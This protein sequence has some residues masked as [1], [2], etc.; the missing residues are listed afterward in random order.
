MVSNAVTESITSKFDI[1]KKKKK[2]KLNPYSAVPARYH[3][4]IPDVSVTME[5]LIHYQTQ[6]SDPISC[7]GNSMER[8]NQIAY[9]I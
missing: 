2:K 3:C 6:S 7:C 1:T 9:P 4:D 5:A 8:T